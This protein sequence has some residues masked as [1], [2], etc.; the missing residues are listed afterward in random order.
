MGACLCGRAVGAICAA[1]ED[2]AQGATVLAIEA[3][4]AL[5]GRGRVVALQVGTGPASG[6]SDG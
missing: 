2:A 1:V 4:P 5:G 3:A 6:Q